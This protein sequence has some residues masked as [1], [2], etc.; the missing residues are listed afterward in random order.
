M[1]HVK[2]QWF[3]EQ[4]NRNCHRE[5][6]KI[7]EADFERTVLSHSRMAEVWITMADH[8]T[9]NPGA[10]VYARKKVVMYRN[11]SSEASKLYT[12]A[13]TDV[14]T[15]VNVQARQ[16]FYGANFYISMKDHAKLEANSD[17]IT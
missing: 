16:Q 12:D 4:A 15:K 5:E 8:C 6:T 17:L 1:D 3:R 11:L 14:G 7:L 13:K 2:C 9:D 10:A